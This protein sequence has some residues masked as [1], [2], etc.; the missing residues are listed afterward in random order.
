M[1]P[2]TRPRKKHN[3]KENTSLNYSHTKH[4]KAWHRKRR[5]CFVDFSQEK[6]LE[7]MKRENSRD[8]QRRRNKRKTRFEASSN[9]CLVNESY[10][11]K[12]TTRVHIL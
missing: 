1:K 9:T 6:G 10:I 5:G 12:G 3:Q 4:G 2:K 8:K 7:E 11:I